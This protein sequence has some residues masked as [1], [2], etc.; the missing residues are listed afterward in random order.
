MSIVFRDVVLPPLSGFSASAPSG[1]IIGVI[2]EKGSGV[3]ELLKAAGGVSQPDS[4][5]VRCGSE[6]RFVGL[7][8]AL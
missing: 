5:E 6:R 3:S 7:G 1:A 8:E 4:G 2:G